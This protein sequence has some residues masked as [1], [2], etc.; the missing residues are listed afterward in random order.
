MTD[1]QNTQN[2]QKS[3]SRIGLVLS[4]GGARGAYQA[5][6]LSGIGEIIGH[7]YGDQPFPII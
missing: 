7:D 6:V 2:P 5:G 1:A 3:K 4:G